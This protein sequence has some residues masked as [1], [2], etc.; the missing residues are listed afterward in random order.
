MIRED[1]VSDE[2]INAFKRDG[3]VVLRSRFSADWLEL[4]RDG[5]KADLVRPT[6]NFTRHTKDPRAPAYFEDYWAWSK[7]P[8]F[9]DFVYNSPCAPLA[10]QLLGAPSINLVMDNWFLREAGSTSRPPFHQDLSYFDFEGTMCVLWLPLEPV[11]KENGIAFVKGSHLW[12]KLFMRVRFADGHPSYEPTEVAGLTYH[13]PPDVNADPDAYELLQWDMESGDCI[14]F[15]MRTLHGGLASVTP[16]ET[17]R[18]FTLRMTAPDGIIRY[19][20]DWAKDERAQFE[21]AGYREGDRIDGPFFPK[22]WPRE[23][24]QP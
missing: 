19:R 2:E 22:L 1:P 3:A 11:K 6:D 13:P 20:G 7:I 17:V 10:A 14:F 16:T 21:A 24:G 9:T 8:Q 4:L 18:R 5:I 15:D 23:P 12:D